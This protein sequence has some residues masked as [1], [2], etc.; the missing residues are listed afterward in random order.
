MRIR[1]ALLLNSRRPLSTIV[2]GYLINDSGG[3]VKKR[4][5]K[6]PVYI[7]NHP[8]RRYVRCRTKIKNFAKPDSAYD[9]RVFKTPSRR[10]LGTADLLCNPRTGYVPWPRGPPRQEHAPPP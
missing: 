2:K 5:C 8:S 6:T 10:V 4:W 7:S 3:C 9:V 1:T